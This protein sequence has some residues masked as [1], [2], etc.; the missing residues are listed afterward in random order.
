MKINVRFLENLR[1]EAK[2]D[3]FTVISD[4]PI[5]Y[6]GDG[7][8]P[9]P[10]DYFLA[11]SA[12]CAAYFVKVYCTARGIP[13]D[14]IQITQENRVDPENRYRQTFKLQ[15][16]IPDEISE[17][18]RKGIVRAMDRCTVKRVIQN[19]LGFEIETITLSEKALKLD[20]ETDFS[21]KTL[22]PG[23]DAPLET[24]IQTLSSLI[25]S[26]GI[27]LEIVSWRNPIPHVWSVHVRDADSP[28]CFANGKGATKNAA[29]CSA[30]GEFIERLSTLFFY[31]DFY[32]SSQWSSDK[33]SFFPHEKWF[34]LR[35][36]DQFPEDLMDETLLRVFNPN[37]ELEPNHLIDFNTNDAS[38][39]VC[40]LPFIRQSDQTKVY[41]PVGLLGNIYVSNGMSAGNTLTEAKVQALSEV[42]ERGIKNKIIQEEIALPDLPKY[43]IDRYPKIEEGIQSL[44][45]KGY[46][47]LLKDASLGGRFPVLCMILLIP[48]TGGVFASFGAHP[49]FEVALERCLTE[50]LQ[51]RGFQ[52]L[53]EFPTPTFNQ[54]EVRQNY[55][56]VEHFIDSSGVVSWKLLSD[57]PSFEYQDWDFQGTTEEELEYLLRIF[58]QLE[59]E[60]YIEEIKDLGVQACRV[61]VPGFSEI[62]EP[63]DLV[64]NNQN[65][66][67]AFRKR[68]LSLHRLS[69]SEL[70]TLVIDLE[71]LDTDSF[72]LISEFI[73]VAFDENTA[74]GKCTL[75]ELKG[76][77]HLAVGNLESAKD[78]I[79]EFLHFNVSLPDRQKYIRLLKALLDIE[80]KEELDFKNYQRSLELLYS[81]NAVET[82]LQSIRGEI[83]FYGLEEL[84]ETLSMIEP[85]RRLIQSY[86]KFMT[87]RFDQSQQ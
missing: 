53:N 3:D 66:A 34:S 84:D 32:L 10:F 17:K 70:K 39:G 36:S 2:F 60:V 49:K 43:V 79:E 14:E 54:D 29:L 26:F 57:Q 23:K 81:V 38:R 6:H 76:L 67:L 46:P 16:V 82:A 68:I 83:R 64:W 19:D 51:G 35:A 12:L 37:G 15:A 74:W 52:Q 55:N 7:S 5:R 27:H 1:L 8:A 30:L 75:N 40:A 71:A 80:L 86:E 22:I 42:F 13:T 41:I 4:Q 59:K 24:T 44:E 63:E 33:F 11:S 87:Y 45:A 62:Y 47:V 50:L 56:L 72:T 48:E 61:I 58:N 31:N 85:H 18:D 25:E 28:L 21:K 20:Y 69:D 77:I 9:G 65:Q 78:H 73:G